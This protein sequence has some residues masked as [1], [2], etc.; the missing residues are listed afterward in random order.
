[1]TEKYKKMQLSMYHQTIFIGIF[2]VAMI[3][4]LTAMTYLFSVSSQKAVVQDS[5]N[6]AAFVAEINK[7]NRSVVVLKSLYQVISA[8]KGVDG[9]K[10]LVDVNASQKEISTITQSIN[11]NK[12]I[13][14]EI[15]TQLL[16]LNKNVELIIASGKEMTV[17]FLSDDI[18]AAEKNKADLDKTI[19]TSFQVLSAVAENISNDNAQTFQAKL[20]QESDLVLLIAAFF[21]FGTIVV[22]FFVGKKIKSTLALL[23]DK[24]KLLSEE[25]KHISEKLFHYS[26]QVNSNATKQADSILEIVSA[27]TE[28]TSMAQ[29]NA[30]NAA[31]SSDNVS[32]SQFIV[33]QGQS[34][35]ND[36]NDSITDIRHSIDLILNQVEKSNMDLDNIVEIMQAISEKTSVINDIVIQTKLLSFNAS[37]EAAR[38]GEAGKG[39]SVVASEIA[40]LA[41]L[42]GEAA[43][44]ID[45]TLNTNL[46]HVRKIAVEMKNSVSTLVGNC[47][48]K[49]NHGKSQAEKC[50]EILDSI[51]HNVENIKM[52]VSQISMASKE[53]ATGVKDVNHSMDQ[54]NMASTETK[55]ASEDSRLA[56]ESL[57]VLTESM[58]ENIFDLENKLLGNKKS[59]SDQTAA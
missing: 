37:I 59:V 8:T 45:E 58:K 11:E 35:V 54:I 47:A 19:E 26:V 48:D 52:T 21:I 38:A 51:V 32:S 40:K 16:E 24:F 20:K 36:M 55:K 12:G 1:M 31:L 39:F 2:N 4:C 23:V 25:N 22:S 56:A 29:N 14:P 41:V 13:K 53:Q 7:L 44:N 5:K 27:L 34:V 3:V 10:Y 9:L 17:N 57:S 33:Q 15:K 18:P 49:V 30:E 6:Q 28:I 43:K 50:K 42:S 46:S